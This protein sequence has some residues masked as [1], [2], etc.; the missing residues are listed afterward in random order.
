MEQPGCGPCCVLWILM[1]ICG[2]L[3]APGMGNACSVAFWSSVLWQM[4]TNISVPDSQ[5]FI[6]K[7]ECITSIHLIWWI[8]SETVQLS[9][10]YNANW[11]SWWSVRG[12]YKWFTSTWKWAS[13]FGAA[14]FFGKN[15]P[16]GDT[17]QIF[18]LKS[19]FF[20]KSFCQIVPLF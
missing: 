2:K 19:P 9:V 10:M 12:D 18:W 5:S 20:L 14:I 11:A 3:A 4:L 16:K 13:L 15:S 6:G 1:E 8:L 17:S 7:H